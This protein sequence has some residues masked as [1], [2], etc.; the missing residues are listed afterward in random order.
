M[1]ASPKAASVKLSKRRPWNS[2]EDSAILELVGRY[3]FK[4]WTVISDQLASEY[5]IIGRTGKQCRERWHNHLNPTTVKGKWSIDEELKLFESHRSCGNKWAD[6]SNLLP[7][8]SDNA[9]KNHFYS[10]MR[11]QYRKLFGLEASQ[12]QLRSQDE[13]LTAEVLKGL[14]RRSKQ[15][16]SK[17]PV[18]SEKAPFEALSY[19]K[20]HGSGAKFQGTNDL[21]M[22]DLQ[23]TGTHLDLPTPSSPMFSFD[24]YPAEFSWLESS[25]DLFSI[26]EVFMLPWG[27]KPTDSFSVRC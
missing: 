6:I 22:M 7:G 4:H 10:A 25:Q 27:F 14:I 17:T 15:K 11:K 20:K 26:D 16:K 8:R 19:S 9:I 5:G 2:E 18:H 23:V 1:E 12:E 13:I 3:G 21:L 24:E